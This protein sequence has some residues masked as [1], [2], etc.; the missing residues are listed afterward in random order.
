M[1][2]NR[3][4]LLQGELEAARPQYVLEPAAA[5][6][7][8][9]DL[10]RRLPRPSS[11]RLAKKQQLAQQSEEKIQD[12]RKQRESAEAHRRRDVAEEMEWRASWV[13]QIE[14]MPAARP[15]SYL[16]RCFMAA[17]SDVSP[18]ANR[19]TNLRLE[20]VCDREERLLEEFNSG[21]SRAR[22][23]SQQPNALH[24]LECERRDLAIKVQDKVLVK[25]FLSSISSDLA[26]RDTEVVNLKKALCE[27]TMRS[28]TMHSSL[29]S[30]K[31]EIQLLE[32]NYEAQRASLVSSKS[33]IVAQDDELA[34]LRK[35]LGE[36]S[37]QGAAEEGRSGQGDRLS[38]LLRR[39]KDCSTTACWDSKEES[40]RLAKLVTDLDAELGQASVR[41]QDAQAELRQ[42]RLD[43]GRHGAEL[44]FSRD[45]RDAAASSFS[46]ARRELEDL[47]G[48]YSDLS[49]ALENAAMERVDC[50]MEKQSQT[51]RAERLEELNSRL[52]LDLDAISC[53]LP[54]CTM[55]G[56]QCKA[57]L[58]KVPLS[59]SSTMAGS[60]DSSMSSPRSLR[61]PS[62]SR[63]SSPTVAPAP[64]DSRPSSPAV[65]PTSAIGPQSP[66]GLPQAPQ[67]ARS[68]K[69]L[70]DQ[71]RRALPSHL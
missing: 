44:Q 9:G 7:R 14:L 51:E 41:L 59:C 40:T 24:D 15:P 53:V 12:N 6:I 45:E 64:Q 11:A 5:L 34:A 48:R 65:A 26:A 38:G 17:A 62:D 67:Q 25:P 8:L 29:E 2:S 66:Q 30:M 13:Q 47:R 27:V 71:S 56:A 50:A 35:V 49:A 54:K 28:D 55:C 33:R 36:A 31:S 1:E 61:S 43:A 4:W 46:A 58:A 22:H 69:A 70:L 63:P 57:H 16:D 52:R 3:P 68:P 32:E 21:Q 23:L 42:H 10:H 20:K 37:L 39:L 19:W 60:L 18:G